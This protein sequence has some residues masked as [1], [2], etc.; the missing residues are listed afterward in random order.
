MILKFDKMQAL[1]NDFVFIDADFLQNHS[2]NKDSMQKIS[3]RKYGIG[4]D[5]I[6][7][8][9]K[10]ASSIKT[11]FYNQ[12]GGEAEICGNALRCL[13]LLIKMRHNLMQCHIETAKQ[14]LL[15]KALPDGKF[16]AEMPSPCFFETP[17]VICEELH[18]NKYDY[19]S[20]GNPHLILFFADIPGIDNVNKIGNILSTHTAFPQGVNVSFAKIIAEDSIYLKS[21]ERGVG[22]TLACGS[23]A[24]ASAASAYKHGLIS[25]SQIN[26]VQDGGILQVDISNDYQIIQ[27]GLASHV[28][29]GEIEQ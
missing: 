29:C 17:H 14:T 1:G 27:T 13:G 15:V 20:I 5:Q 28:F 11:S 24:C 9:K 26:I 3:D 16:S 4:C 18:T 2:I 22:V 25:H 19:L 7:V 12:G 21:F 10:N 23:A 6:I 8:Y